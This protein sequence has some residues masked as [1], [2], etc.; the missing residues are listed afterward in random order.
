[1]AIVAMKYVLFLSHI[2]ESEAVLRGLQ[3]IG[4]LHPKHI[5]RAADSEQLKNLEHKLHVQSTVIKSLSDRH[6]KNHAMDS[7]ILP[8][9]W[10]VE[11]WLADEKKFIEGIAKIERE[12]EKQACLGDFN[13]ED[14]KRLSHNG[15]SLQLWS[16]S[17]REFAEYSKKSEVHIHVISSHD[18][19]CFATLSL[20]GPVELSFALEREVPNSSLS[21][22]R[23]ELSDLRRRLE[24]ISAQIDSATAY[25]PSYRK[26]NVALTEERDFYETLSR[27]FEEE[28]ISAFAGWVPADDIEHVE[29]MV[30][31]SF[32][33][34]FMKARDPMEDENPPIKTKN[35]WLASVFEPLLHILGF[36][37]YGGIDPALFFAPST[38][39]FF[40]ICFSDAGYGAIMVLIGAIAKKLLSAKIPAIRFVSNMT[41]LLGLTTVVWGLATGS[42][43]GI[44]FAQREWILVDVAP[45]VGDPMLLFKISIVAGVLHISIALMISII[46]SNNFSERMIK[47]G[48]L[49][50]LW[51]G[52]LAMI[53]YS[54]WPYIAGAGI[55]LILTFSSDAKNPLKRLGAGIWGVY[56]LTGL[57]GDVM[58]Y[59]RLFGLGVASGAIASVINVLAV[60]VR[61]AVPVVGI[62]L[63]IIVL[64]LGHSFNFAMGVMGALVHPARLHAVEAFPKCVQ[65]SGAPYKPLEKI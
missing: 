28:S 24:S 12:I 14:V 62:L 6:I 57:L 17:K 46:S 60:D 30:H 52:A 54:I 63:S 39:L 23:D 36:P 40:G 37:K 31:K 41:I 43:F 10:D 64:L 21:A 26:K 2:S 13:P 33:G 32:P 20:K 29:E 61:G 16:A 65:L 42:I 4:V 55:L 59:A 35:S 49:F 19:V 53:K 48:T 47:A 3:D 9:I 25:L 5:K 11:S 15:V 50:V 45:D 38:M 7:A 56:G 18:D 1:M 22:L 27:A 34:V 8:S 44:P 51:G 58:S